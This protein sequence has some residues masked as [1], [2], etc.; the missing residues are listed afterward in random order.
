MTLDEVVHSMDTGS[1][2]ALLALIATII[3]SVGTAVWFL[4][5][6]IGSIK[7]D[8]QTSK[9]ELSIEVQTVSGEV[10]TLTGRINTLE[11]DNYT[12]PEAEA[13]A[14]RLAMNNPGLRVPDP[15]QP[16]TLITP[17]MENPS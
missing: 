16:H 11:R 15:R 7:S 10:R 2:I 13:H 6:L 5:S 1:V 8:V 17:H 14:L 9:T 4:A 12:K 3:G